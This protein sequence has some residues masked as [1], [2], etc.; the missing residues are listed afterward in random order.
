MVISTSNKEHSNKCLM[1]GHHQSSTT[2]QH[3]GPPF[4]ALQRPLIPPRRKLVLKP[5]HK[6]FYFLFRVTTAWEDTFQEKHLEGVDVESKWLKCRRNPKWNWCHSLMHQRVISST[7]SSGCVPTRV[8][9][10]L[11]Q[12]WRVWTRK[13]WSGSLL[14][15]KKMDMPATQLGPLTQRMNILQMIFLGEMRNFL[16]CVTENRGRWNMKANTLKL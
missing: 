6:S 3:A 5:L 4:S 15:L 11:R 10:L 13:P 14:F 2:C 8:R 1:S 16:S 9:N 12:T 7:A